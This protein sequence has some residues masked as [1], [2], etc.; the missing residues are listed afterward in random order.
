MY[1]QTYTVQSSHGQPFPEEMLSAEQCFPRNHWDV[2]EIIK[3]RR[4]FAPQVVTLGRWV[5]SKK[6]RPLWKR[7]ESHGWKVLESQTR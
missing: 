2:E 5:R 7:W 3:S 1:F 6:D 4:D